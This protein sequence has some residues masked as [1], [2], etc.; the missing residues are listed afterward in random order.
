MT[1]ER[2]DVARLAASAAE[3]PL[4]LCGAVANELEFLDLCPRVVALDVDTETLKQRLATRTTNDFGK[5]AH[6]L[7]QVLGWH[8]QVR[9]AYGRP[10]HSIV[11]ATKPIEE[12][13]QAVLALTF[14]LPV[15]SG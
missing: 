1:A 7:Q 9:A 12:V 6:E 10:G 2:T 15:G 8:A 4:F 11:D 5:S 3:R 13:V 14:G